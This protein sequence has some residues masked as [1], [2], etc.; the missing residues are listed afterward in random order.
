MALAVKSQQPGAKPNGEPLSTPQL[1]RLMGVPSNK[2]REFIVDG[3][4]V[5]RR[6]GQGTPNILSSADCIQWLRERG[7]GRP[8]PKTSEN[9]PKRRIESLRAEEI[10]LEL[11]KKRGEVI[12][13]D[14][15]E[16]WARDEAAKLRTATVDII[17]DA[18]AEFGEDAGS[19]LEDRLSRMLNRF[20]NGL[21]TAGEREE[22]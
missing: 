17:R 10:E 13:I 5:F 4:P 18:R 8:G 19:W 12:T 16:P 14:K 3:M 6:G 9:D 15:I 2:I 11:A 1:A 20:A 22:V 7:I 21:A